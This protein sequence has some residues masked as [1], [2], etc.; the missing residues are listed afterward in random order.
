M[1]I[2]KLLHERKAQGRKSFAVLIDP[3]KVQDAHQLA[4]LIRQAV[5]SKVDF[6][7]VG[8]SL[9]TQDHLHEVVLYL[10]KESSIP[11]L[12]FPGN[13]LQ[14]DFNADAILLLSLISGRNP[15][16]LIGQHVVAAP[17]IK[18]SKLEVLS[19]GY[20]L[21]DGQNQTSVAYMSNTQ[22]IPAKKSE[23]AV[24]TAMAAEMIG[25]QNLYL[26]AGSGAAQPVP[27][28]MITQVHKNTEMPLWVGGGIRHLAEAKA[29]VLAGADVLVVGN[30]IEKNPG[31]MTEV[32]EY[33]FKYNARLSNVHE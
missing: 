24:C 6:F 26:E 10:K 31:F 5:E 32:S 29:A 9:M 22:P 4:P 11:V 13:N 23:I 8:G 7:L 20:M 25:M 3:D 15:E 33:L 1:K 19:T 21:V 18:K 30:A 12:L 14:L 28:K 17:L 27:P 2:Q 16:Y